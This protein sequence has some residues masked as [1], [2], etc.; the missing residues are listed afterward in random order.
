MPKLG[1]ALSG[2]GFRATLY[3]LGVVRFLR[4]ADALQH[5]TDVASVSGGSIVAAHLVLNWDRYNGDDKDFAEA[6]AEIVRFVQFDVRN[7]IV[8]RLPMQYVLRL[9][10]RFHLWGGRRLTPNSILERYYRDRLYG[11]RCLYELPEQPML[12]LLTTNVSSGGLSVF[13]RH[14]LFI[15]RRAGDHGYEAVQIPGQMAGLPKVV[16]ASSAFPGFFPPTEI[17]AA[18]LGVP[19]G[20]FPTEYFTDGG[21]YDNLGLRAF[22]WLRQHDGTFD[23]V[24]VSDAGKP[25]QVLTDAALG[26]VGQALR[27]SDILMDRV[28]QLELEN[29]GSRE[30]F[31]FF[32]MTAT[33]DPSE[34]PTAM[35]LVVQSEVQGIRT[36]LDRFSE[37]EINVLSRHG[38]E[39]A[40]MVCRQQGVLG[41]AAIPECPPWTPIPG[42][43]LAPREAARPQTHEPALATR[44]ARRLRRS[45]HRRVFSTLLD[46]RD[47][48]SYVYVVLAAVVFLYLPL[49]VYQLYRQSVM[50]AEIIHSITS[51]DPDLREILQLTTSDP[52]ADWVAEEVHEKAEPTVANFDGVEILEHSRIHDLRRWNPE[53][54]SHERQGKVYIRDRITLQKLSSYSGD[55]HITFTF[56][57][58]GEDVEFREPNQEFQGVISRITEPVEVA[59]QLRTVYEFEYD[60]SQVLPEEPVTIEVEVIGTFPPTVRAPFMTYAKTDL[61]SVWL[62]FSTDRP[63]R[64]YELV[65]YPIDGSEGP[66]RM[67]SRYSIDHPYGQLIGWSVVNPDPDRKYEC[68]WTLE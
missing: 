42:Q 8:R 38:Y 63:Y 28:W 21:V 7:H 54:G 13:N 12:H 61:I 62:L 30:G 47:W 18:D 58:R 23:Q 44:V 50:Q 66:S 20:Q 19:E 24:L 51:G 22:S 39:V 27:S 67:R 65:S 5:V 57:F 41:D 14:G 3:H 1:L 26:V 2:G 33:V 60:L 11:D 48:P 4:D 37:Q 55:G 59:G 45:G 25:F 17:T 53:A 34:D 40:R 36:D 6:A 32:P 9:L 46:W 52:T 64:T 56:P 29:F 10:A 31:V 35:P 43:D 15:Q 49:K 16:G 68:R